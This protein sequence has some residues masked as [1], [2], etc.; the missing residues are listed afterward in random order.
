MKNKLT[1]MMARRFSSAANTAAGRQRGAT[2]LEY[3]VL[4]AVIVI[5]LFIAGA[6]FW[7]G[8]E[9]GKGVIGDVFS[10]I[11]DNLTG[12]VGPGE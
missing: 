12:K 1:E 6:V 11:G 3:L 5:G 8:G 2:A 10:E 7:G 4:A 9:G